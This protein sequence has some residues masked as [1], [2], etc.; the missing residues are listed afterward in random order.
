MNKINIEVIIVL[1]LLLVSTLLFIFSNLDNALLKYFWNAENGWFLAE[2]PPWLQ[3]REYSSIPALFIAIGAIFLFILGLNVRKFEKYRKHCLYLILLMLLAPGL[4]VNTILKENFGR[5]RPRDTIQFNGKY[6]YEKPLVYDT[7]SPGKSFPCGH[8]SMGFYFFAFYIL[9]R[10]RNKKFA[11]AAFGI[12]LF[13]GGLIGLTRMVQG[14]HY[15]SDVI[16]S[17]F[18]CYLSALWLYHIFRFE[19]EFYF[20]PRSGISSGKKRVF[21]II[22]SILMVLIIFAV[23]LAT[24]VNKWHTVNTVN[25]L[26]NNSNSLEIDLLLEPAEIEIIRADSLF[27]RWNYQGFGAPKSRLRSLEEASLID[28]TY[29]LSVK[30]YKVG[31]FTEFQQNIK[32]YLPKNQI[33]HLRYQIG[34]ELF[35]NYYH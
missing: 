23:T 9:N 35:E 15:L 18:I 34:D 20:V 32:I 31:F 19:N 26:L 5:P 29:F 11:R 12:T 7:A 16:W 33:T 27:I 28:S 14:A 3:I 4:I 21:T 8:A 30:Q 17:A 22:A 13:W 1:I 10:K 6:N 24:P 25:I 2:L